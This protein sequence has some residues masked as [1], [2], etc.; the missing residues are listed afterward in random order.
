MTAESLDTNFTK[1]LKDFLGIDIKKQ[2]KMNS[3]RDKEGYEKY[4]E[5]KQNMRFDK[6][7][8]NEIY[9]RRNIHHFYTE[10]QIYS[11]IDRWSIQ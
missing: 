7:M 10:K 1:A 5:I 3:A 8:L 2:R 9:D 11:I 4:L 6:E